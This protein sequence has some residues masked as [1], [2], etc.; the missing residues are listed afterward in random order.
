HFAGAVPCLADAVVLVYFAN[1]DRYRGQYAPFQ[2]PDLDY[3]HK[4]QRITRKKYFVLWAVI[5][6]GGHNRSAHASPARN[7]SGITVSDIRSFKLACLVDDVLCPKQ[8]T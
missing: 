1:Y 2:H 7:P 8:H 6:A 5:R 3:N 4:P